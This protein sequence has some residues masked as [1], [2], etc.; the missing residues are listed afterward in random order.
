M[1]PTPNVVHMRVKGQEDPLLETTR[2]GSE[3]DRYKDFPNIYP[4][5][6][7]AFESM[8]LRFDSRVD[9]NL[10]LCY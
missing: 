2:Y 7:T 9:K 10:V 8:Q 4:V 5:D 6:D 1:P 3:T